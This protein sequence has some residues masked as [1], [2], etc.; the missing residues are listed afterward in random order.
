VRLYYTTLHTNWIVYNSPDEL[1]DEVRL[2]QLTPDTV[3]LTVRLKAGKRL[4]GY[5]PTFEGNAL[6]LELKR[7]PAA[8]KAPLAGMRVFLDPG[9]MP[10]APGAIGPL[11]TKEM[12][13]NFAIAQA[14]EKKLLKE[15]AVPLL[16]RSGPDDEVSLVDR[17]RLAVEKKAD[18]FVSIHNNFLSAGLNPFK[19]NPHGYSTFYY[20]PHSLEL[21]RAVHAAYGHHVPLPS[22]DLRFGN[23]LVCRL[24]AMPAILTESAY[25]TYPEQEA[26][27]LDAKFR[28]KIADAIVE[29]LRDF[30]KKARERRK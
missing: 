3:V 28:D 29:G 21:A 26:Q 17:P 2:K 19:G 20:H 12:D 23:L 11:G 8:A 18:V 30:F 9:H 27:L 1:V 6:R 13:V 4:W 16:S 24:S 14:V 22:E 25:L 15:G 5:W 10:S 7:P